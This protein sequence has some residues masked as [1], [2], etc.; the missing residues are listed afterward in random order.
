LIGLYYDYNAHMKLNESL[1]F[2]VGVQ[3][4]LVFNLLLDVG[5][6]R[7]LTEHMTNSVVGNQALPGPNRLDL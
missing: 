6:V 7:T 1:Q 2:N 3:R 4:E 5:Y